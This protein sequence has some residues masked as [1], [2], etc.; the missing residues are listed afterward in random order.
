MEELELDIF[1]SSENYTTVT[2]SIR[3]LFTQPGHYIILLMRDEQPTPPDT[4]I[5]ILVEYPLIGTI[6]SN[7]SNEF[8][9]SEFRDV[10]WDI[11]HIM[12]KVIIQRG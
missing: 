12:N 7:L 8:D 1:S 10:D 5:K 4:L 3:N 6:L 9:N 2:N 11:C